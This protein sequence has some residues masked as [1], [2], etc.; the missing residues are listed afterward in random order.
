MRVTL[1][2]TVVDLDRNEWS[3]NGK[4]GIAFSLLVRGDGQSEAQAANK[5]RVSP[6][7]FGRFSK[8]DRVT[9]LPVDV[10]ANTVEYQGVI[11]G[12]KLSCTLD[13]EYVGGG[14]HSSTP[15]VPQPA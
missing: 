14:K 8:G 10:F 5:V 6:E 12:A 3:F 7:Q 15:K 13:R 11:T 4:S 1:S 2:G 9:D